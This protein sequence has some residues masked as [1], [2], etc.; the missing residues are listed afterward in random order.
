M[1]KETFKISKLG[2]GLVKEITSKRNL[3]IFHGGTEIHEFRG[4]VC[5]KDYGMANNNNDRIVRFINVKG[6][7][8][9]F[10]NGSNLKPFEG[11]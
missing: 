11:K 5:V 10:C 1:I 9:E 4:K 6:F 2:K 8:I 3:Y 7:P